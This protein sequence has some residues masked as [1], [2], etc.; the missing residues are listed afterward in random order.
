MCCEN[1]TRILSHVARHIRA[2]ISSRSEVA[3]AAFVLNAELCFQLSNVSPA[4]RI[5]INLDVPSDILPDD[6]A[7][8]FD[9]LESRLQFLR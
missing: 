7:M 9:E 4:K 2:T 5:L 3:L 1:V 6:R 8:F